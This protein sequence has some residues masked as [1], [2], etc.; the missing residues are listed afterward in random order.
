MDSG[1]LR[2]DQLHQRAR[3][4]GP[5]DACARRKHTGHAEDGNSQHRE[6]SRAA[7]AQ[8]HR[9]PTSESS[10]RRNP[11]DAGVIA[12][13]L[14]VTFPNVVLTGRERRE[15]ARCRDGEDRPLDVVMFENRSFDNLLGYL[16]T[17]P[18]RR[19]SGAAD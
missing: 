11:A 6:Q 1:P 2:V 14:S 13:K 4:E 9:W 5:N 7:R 18:R 12:S 15:I 10:R 16:R 8:H 19:G 3:S 17:S